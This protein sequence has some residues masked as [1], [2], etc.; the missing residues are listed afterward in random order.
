MTDPVVEA[1][2]RAIWDADRRGRGFVPVPAGEE[3]FSTHWKDCAKVAIA[4]RSHTLAGVAFEFK[5][6]TIMAHHIAKFA[7]IIIGDYIAGVAQIVLTHK[8]DPDRNLHLAPQNSHTLGIFRLVVL[9]A[10]QCLHSKIRCPFI[11]GERWT[12]R[13]TVL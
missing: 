3:A 12:S 1:V 7:P 5:I 8:A 2:A 10:K 11:V 9:A 6:R 13:H 4:A